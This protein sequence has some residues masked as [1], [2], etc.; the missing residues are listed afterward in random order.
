MSYSSED[1]QEPS[2]YQL[3][4]TIHTYLSLFRSETATSTYTRPHRYHI[5]LWFLKRRA[6]Q[7]DINYNCLHLRLPSNSS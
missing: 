2:V 3:I 4:T 7:T 6:P 1:L 5:N